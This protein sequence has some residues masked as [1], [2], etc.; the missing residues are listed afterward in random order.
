MDARVAS[1]ESSMANLDSKINY[2]VSNTFNHKLVPYFEQLRCELQFGG[3]REGP[4]AFVV[5][6]IPDPQVVEQ[7][8]PPHSLIFAPGGQTSR[9]QWFP[10]MTFLDSLRVMTL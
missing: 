5:S 8:Q 7:I 4:S 6:G 2:A 9:S 3:T 1:L 10:R